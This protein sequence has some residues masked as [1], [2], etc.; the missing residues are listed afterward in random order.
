MDMIAEIRGLLLG[1]FLCFLITPFVIGSF[2]LFFIDLAK[3]TNEKRKVKLWIKILFILSV[4]FIL[5]I[6][7]AIIFMIFAAGVYMCAPR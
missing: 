6:I 7:G 5:L 1:H 4:L 3:A 2:V